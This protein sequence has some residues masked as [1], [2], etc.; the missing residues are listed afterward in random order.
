ARA[1]AG[2]RQRGWRLVIVEPQSPLTSDLFDLSARMITRIV[3]CT[4]Y[5]EPR[6]R[7]NTS[8]I[9]MGFVSI[10]YDGDQRC[11]RFGQRGRLEKAPDG[12]NQPEKWACRGVA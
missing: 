2:G 3:A 7:Q 1:R 6:T 9:G 5:R 10:N 4:L 8:E 12:S 11:H